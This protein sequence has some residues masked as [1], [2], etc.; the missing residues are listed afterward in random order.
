MEVVDFIKIITILNIKPINTIEN[1]YLILHQHERSLM[2]RH[3]FSP[4]RVHRFNSTILH[5][6]FKDLNHELRAISNISRYNLMDTFH[7]WI[8]KKKV[9]Y[10]KKIHSHIHTLHLQSAPV[11]HL[12]LTMPTLSSGNTV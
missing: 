8:F 10:F 5:E 3:L 2:L 1:K 12:R 6:E 4:L 7:I 9:T 11:H